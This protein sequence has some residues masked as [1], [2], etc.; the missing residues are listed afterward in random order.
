[1]KTLFTLEIFLNWLLQPHVSSV[2]LLLPV[3]HMQT[4]SLI[5]KMLTAVEHA[6]RAKILQFSL[7][8]R[9]A[10][11]NSRCS[12]GRPLGQIK[13]QLQSAS[14]QNR[15]KGGLREELNRSRQRELLGA[16]RI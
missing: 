14:E 5:A 10:A 3:K 16:Q 7:V 2:L 12:T 9:K 11:F 15:E 6:T 8:S 1:M 13:L 4:W